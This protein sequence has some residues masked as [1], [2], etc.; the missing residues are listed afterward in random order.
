VNRM[1]KLWNAKLNMTSMSICIGVSL[2][3]VIAA[4]FLHNDR[5]AFGFAVSTL[6]L[7]VAAL[8]EFWLKDQI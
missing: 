8:W 1:K 5:L 2:T 7:S 3:G 4:T 6:G